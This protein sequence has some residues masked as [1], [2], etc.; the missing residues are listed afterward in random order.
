MIF[1]EQIAALIIEEFFAKVAVM[2]AT[3]VGDQGVLI[4]TH[5]MYVSAGLMG[6]FIASHAV[7]AATNGGFRDVQSAAHTNLT[8]VTMVK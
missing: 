1:V 3:T 8:T 6:D 2:V 7:P 4:V 5:M